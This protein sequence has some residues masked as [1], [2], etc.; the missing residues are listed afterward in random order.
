MLFSPTCISQLYMTY[1]RLYYIV[2][3][4]YHFYHYWRYNGVPS[5][6]LLIYLMYIPKPV[7]IKKQAWIT[8][9]RGVLMGLIPQVVH[10]VN[11]QPLRHITIYYINYRALDKYKDSEVNSL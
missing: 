3:F 1:Y 11:L 4:Y 9:H 6:P 10:Y 8:Y 7:V 5:P 2:F